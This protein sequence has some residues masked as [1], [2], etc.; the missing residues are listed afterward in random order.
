MS[1]IFRIQAKQSFDYENYNLKYDEQEAI[2]IYTS[3][4]T[5]PYDLENSLIVRLLNRNSIVLIQG[6]FSFILNGIKIDQIGSTIIGIQIYRDI[7]RKILVYQTYFKIS[8]ILINSQQGI[9]FT[10]PIQCIDN[11]SIKITETT[12]NYYLT[13]QVRGNESFENNDSGIF[14]QQYSILA[15]EV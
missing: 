10:I 13:I 4:I 7:K 9:N 14:L 5:P 15:M 1:R 12:I 2:P 6:Q 11:P 8:G 3:N